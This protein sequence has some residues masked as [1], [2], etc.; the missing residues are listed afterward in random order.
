VYLA[1]FWYVDTFG[2][3]TNALAGAL[4]S[5]IP[6]HPLGGAGSPYFFE[7][8]ITDKLQTVGGGIFISEGVLIAGPAGAVTM[9]GILGLLLRYTFLSR[10]KWLGMVYMLIFVLAFRVIWYGW[11]YILPSMYTLFISIALLRFVG[12]LK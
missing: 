4:Y 10:N 6:L 9:S 8:I 2:H 3:N 7:K 12:R 1:S 5:F 11:E